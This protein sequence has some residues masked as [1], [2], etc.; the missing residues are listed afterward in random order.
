MNGQ[1]HIDEGTIRRAI[2][3]RRILE[4]LIS[5]E[6]S[7]IGDMKVLVNVYH[8][9]LASVPTLTE[10]TRESIRRNLLEILQLHEDLLG[11]LHRVIPNSEYN[12]DTSVQP[13]TT[14]NGTARTSNVTRQ[15]LS[16]C[17]SER[18]TNTGDEPITLVALPRIV[19]DV[20]RVF[21]AFVRSSPVAADMKDCG[22]NF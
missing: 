6:E 1:G 15:R 10:L 16:S 17:Y 11:E 2:Q 4:E 14:S 19:E 5:S 21:N 7:Y 8:T 20:A 9:L 18:T 13:P 3:R 22:T 12:E